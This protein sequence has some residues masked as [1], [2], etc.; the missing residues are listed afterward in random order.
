MRKISQLS[1][2]V[3][4]AAVSGLTFG[5]VSGKA[6]PQ[7]RYQTTV[8]RIDKSFQSAQSRCHT[9][10]REQL[11]LCL[12]I[13][14]AEKWRGMADAQVRLN[15]TPEARRSQRVIVAGGELL[16]ALQK[17]SSNAAGAREQCRDAAKDSFLREVSRAQVIEAREQPCYPA[18]CAWLPETARRNETTSM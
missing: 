8:Q 4:I 13:A 3:G 1:V 2:A 6:D 18:D 5:F 17:C 11:R 15:D 9:L 7:S 14:L 16:V 12:A 10:P